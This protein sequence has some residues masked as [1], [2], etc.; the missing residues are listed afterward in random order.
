MCAQIQLT[1]YNPT[2]SHYIAVSL[3][4]AWLFQIHAQAGVRDRPWWQSHSD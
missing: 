3:Y 4:P 1:F 2:C